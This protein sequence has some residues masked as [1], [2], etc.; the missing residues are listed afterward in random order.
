MICS[1]FVAQKNKQSLL[2]L[3]NICSKNNLF[4]LNFM[5]LNI[6]PLWTTAL[7]WQRDLCNSMKLWA[8]LCRVT[9]DGWV[10]VK[11]SGKTWSTGGGN[12]K[13]LQYSCCKNLM[14]SIKRQKD[15][16]LEDEPLRPE[17]VQY[18]TWKER[19]AITNSP[20]KNEAAGP[21]QK[22]HLVVDVSVG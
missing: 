8:M 5:V 1:D 13:A 2:L 16:M 15:M 12:G 9:Q 3:H 19:R 10:I 17:N 21:K 4:S 20:R 7:S 14:N 11:S 22:W 6:T 18:A